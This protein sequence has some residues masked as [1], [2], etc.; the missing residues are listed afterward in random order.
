M[1]L[2]KILIS[3]LINLFELQLFSII[4]KCS[5]YKCVSLKN[6][7]SNDNVSNL[8]FQRFFQTFTVQECILNGFKK[9]LKNKVRYIRMR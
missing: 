4:D 3:S 6:K 8:I 2:L 7:A 5:F 1:F 9:P